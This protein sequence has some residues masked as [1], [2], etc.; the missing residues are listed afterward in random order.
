MTP[1]VYF[2]LRK[3]RQAQQQV[4][5]TVD[6]KYSLDMFLTGTLPKELE[7]FL[8]YESATTTPETYVGR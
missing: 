4:T 3:L 2:D 1:T 6:P 8:I 5:V 7:N